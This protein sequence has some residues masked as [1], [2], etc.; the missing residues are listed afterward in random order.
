M[1]KQL[2]YGGASA[3]REFLQCRVVDFTKMD[4]QGDEATI[5]AYTSIDSP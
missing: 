3:D 4:F 1:D 2:D 5:L